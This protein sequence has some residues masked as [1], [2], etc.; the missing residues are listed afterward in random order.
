MKQRISLLLVL[1]LSLVQPMVVEA[2]T[3]S[4]DAVVESYEIEKTCG[5]VSLALCESVMKQID[6]AE[7]KA[8]EKAETKEGAKL[9]SENEGSDESGDASG[10]WVNL[11]TYKITYYC[12]CEYCCGNSNGITASGTYAT[13]GRT[14]A[15]DLPLGTRVMIGGHEYVVE[16][17]GGA[18]HGNII[19]MFCNSHQEALEKGVDYEDLY[20]WQEDSD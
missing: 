16:D 13:A 2:N 4:G 1:V 19:D 5:G 3:S 14:I 7:A 18:I 8:E 11:G 9:N 6:I 20:I 15:A 17:R 10:E 12:P